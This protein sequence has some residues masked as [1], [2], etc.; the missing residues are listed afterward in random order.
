MLSAASKPSTKTLV[1]HSEPDNTLVLEVGDVPQAGLGHELALH[2]LVRLRLPL[3]RIP[4]QVWR[5]LERDDRLGAQPEDRRR[6]MSARLCVNNAPSTRSSSIDN[7]I[8]DVASA[9][10]E[11]AEILAAKG[12]RCCLA[13]HAW[14]SLATSFTIGNSANRSVA[15]RADC[16]RDRDG[17]PVELDATRAQHRRLQ[18]LD[19]TQHAM[20]DR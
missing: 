9:K 19:R 8:C 2:R 11:V 4:A 1:P 14:P 16:E 13:A 7:A 18:R 15:K 5:G 10:R 12:A 20:R 6:R 17:A 3:R